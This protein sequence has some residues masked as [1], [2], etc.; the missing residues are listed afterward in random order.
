MGTTSSA[1]TGASFSSL[2]HTLET[3]G[4]DSSVGLPDLPV[5]RPDF[6]LE[7]LTPCECEFRHGGW[8]KRRQQVWAALGRLCVGDVT[9]LRFAC[10]GSAA[11][12]QHSACRSSFRVV[13]NLCRSRWCVPC[14]RAR[15]LRLIKSILPR[16]K[17]GDTRFSTFTLKHSN[18]PL[19]EQITRIL[20]SFNR[21][22]RLPVW[23]ESQQ[24]AAA[25]L[26]VKIGR[27][28]LWHPHLH[29]LSIGSY[30]KQSE[31][32][33]AWK[34]VTGDSWVVD[35]R[36]PASL[37]QVAF[38]VVKYVTKPLDS[39]VF[40]DPSRLDEAIASLKGRRLVNASGSFG[41]INLEPA[42]DGQGDDWISVGRLDALREAARA[43]DAIAVEILHGL[44]HSMAPAG[45]TPTPPGSSPAG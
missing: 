27:D 45:E 30:V 35:I 22:R 38:Y 17:L 15:A 37:N 21:L 9:R 41:R 10:C 25:F 1:P 14:G 40:A 24:G 20:T 44:L 2:V 28:G 4:P 6:D 3:S 29:V 42:D 36:R 39:T 5:V 31:L 32:R 34:K 33:E 16:L 19:R 12:V 8:H 26:E 23:K 11:W 13:A 7:R 43:G 18:A